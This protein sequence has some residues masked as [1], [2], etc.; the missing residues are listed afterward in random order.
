MTSPNPKIIQQELYPLVSPWALWSNLHPPSKT[1]IYDLNHFSDFNGFPMVNNHPK[2]DS[3]QSFINEHNIN[4]FGISGM[5]VTWHKVNFHEHLGSHTSEWF[6]HCHISSA[7]NLH[8]NLHTTLQVG[9]IVLFTTN[10]LTYQVASSGYD[11]TGLR[12]WTWM[13]F[14]GKQA[15]H[16]QIVTCYHPIK[17]KKGPLSV[18]N[19]HCWYFLQQNID[20]CPLKQYMVDLKCNIE[21]WQQEG[22]LIIIGGDWN[23][24]VSNPIWHQFWNNLGL[25]SPAGLINQ[26]PTSTY[27]HSQK[28]LDMVYVAPSLH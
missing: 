4:I 23:E 18:Y 10:K 21:Q 28:Q 9:G 11:S 17:N 16:T 12:Q 24:E 20:L 22:D 8:D 15:N 1:I 6:K 26:T 5:N 3:L 13:H 27:Y 25:V 7:W 2:N 14:R 19:Q